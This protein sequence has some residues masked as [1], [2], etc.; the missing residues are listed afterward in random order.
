MKRLPW[1][2]QRRKQKKKIKILPLFPSY[3]L[4]MARLQSNPRSQAYVLRTR[5]KWCSFLLKA[6]MSSEC[7]V[8]GGLE[9]SEPS[10]KSG[11]QTWGSATSFVPQGRWEET[12]NQNSTWGKFPHIYQI[13][14][15]LLISLILFKRFIKPPIWQPV[16]R[17]YAR[18][19]GRLKEP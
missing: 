14:T 19:F 16:L 15:S 7:P 6:E 10:L 8:E 1:H 12:R 4:W 2:M 18:V 11:G 17:I 9:N 5:Q 13:P 3:N